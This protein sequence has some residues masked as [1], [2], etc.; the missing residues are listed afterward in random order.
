M[1]AFLKRGV[2]V[3]W[4]VDPEDRTVTVYRLNQFPQ[5]AEENEELAGGDELPEFRCR[6]S[7]F[8]QMPGG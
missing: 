8:F 1:Q 4:L 7:D 2:S 5:V 3:A 6:V